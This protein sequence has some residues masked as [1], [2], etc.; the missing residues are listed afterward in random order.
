MT[1]TLIN[2]ESAALLDRYYDE[3]ALSSLP[4]LGHEAFFQFGQ[5]QWATDL[6]E[7]INGE[8]SVIKPIPSNLSA[9]Q[10]VFHT[11]DALYSYNNGSI[12]ISTS[13]STGE[14]PDN[15]AHKL[16]ALGILDAK[17]GLVAA[18]GMLPMYVYSNRGMDVII[19]IK[20][21][22]NDSA[23]SITVKAAGK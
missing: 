1:V 22:K 16:S 6:I 15:E 21:A 8:P 12:I 4:G 10:N 19:T 11:S 18:V 23:E 7:E 2:K 17:A 3:R 13:I 14:I 20:L 9:L 5:I